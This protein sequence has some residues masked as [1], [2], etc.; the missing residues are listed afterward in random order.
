MEVEI[1]KKR[2]ILQNKYNLCYFLNKLETLEV[3]IEKKGKYYKINI[4]FAIFLEIILA[5]CFGKNTW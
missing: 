2:K 5:L 4:T 1:E 3:E